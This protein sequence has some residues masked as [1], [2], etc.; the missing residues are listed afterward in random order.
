[1]PATNSEAHRT[2]EK[3]SQLTSK[4][5]AIGNAAV[6]AALMAIKRKPAKAAP[7]AA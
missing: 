4:Y 1:M 7:K 6:V 5:R 3:A 2:A